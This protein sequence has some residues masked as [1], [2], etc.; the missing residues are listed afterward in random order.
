MEGETSYTTAPPPIFDGEEYELW[1]ARMTTH[2]EAL[3]L[4]EA[5][6]ENYDVPELPLNPTMA[7]MKNHR[8]RKI[9]RD[10]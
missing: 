9:K 10:K 7:Q 3:D 1:A 5:V 4:L 2:L 6:E 8:E